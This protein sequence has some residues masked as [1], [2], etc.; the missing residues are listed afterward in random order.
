[1]KLYGIDVSQ[2]FRSV[3]WLLEMKIIPYEKAALASLLTVRCTIMLHRPQVHTHLLTCFM[4]SLVIPG[5]KSE[6]PLGTKSD[7][8]LKLSPSG[9]VPLLVDTDSTGMNVTISESNAILCYLADKHKLFD[10]YPQDLSTRAQV[11]SWLHWIHFNSRQQNL[12]SQPKP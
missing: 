12:T 8:F 3:M 2:P 10:L 11:N 4:Q 1:M 6:S 7:T 5:A 9:K